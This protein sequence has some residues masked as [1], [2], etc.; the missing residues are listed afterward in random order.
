MISLRDLLPLLDGARR[1]G[2]LPPEIRRVHTDSRSLQAGDLFVALRGERFDAHD[3]LVQ[4]RQAGAAA[5]LA[6]RGLAETGLPGVEVPDSRLALGQLARLWR[7]SC[8][9]PLVAVTGS[10]G[11]TTVTQ[12]IATILRQAAGDAAHATQGNLNNDIG[13]PL[14]LLRLQPSHRFSVIE[15]GMNHPGEIAYLSGLVQPTV[16]LVNNAQREHQEFMETVEAVA[17]ENGEVFRFLRPGGVAV[18]PSDDAAHTPIWRTLAGEHPVMT[19]SESD[20]QSDVRLQVA[21]WRDGAWDISWQSPAGDGSARLHIAGRHNLRNAMAAVACAL[22]AGVPPE[23]IARGLSAF[24]PVGGRSRAISLGIA[25]RRV[26]LVD[27]T[28][29]ANPDSMVAA[30]DVLAELPAPRLLVLGDMGEVGEQGLDFHLEVLRHAHA[31]G[32]CAVHCAGDWMRQAV[33]VLKSTGEPV[34]QH[35]SDVDALAAAVAGQ[36]SGAG[37]PASVLVKGSRFM[38]MERVVKA[39]QAVQEQEGTHHAA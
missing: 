3:F 11:K 20:P 19:F 5:V 23:A 9:L 27:D 2:A 31:R 33:D 28:Y 38:R 1:V 37:G 26:M 32:L 24:A 21:D 10:N 36:V 4:A 6:E 12:M 29:N 13:V 18:F 34:P 14:T 25:G 39:L 35:W 16:A 15:L 17:R 8:E 7:Q 22:A 30:V